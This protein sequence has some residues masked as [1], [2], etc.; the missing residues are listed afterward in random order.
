MTQLQHPDPLDL[1]E[2]VAAGRLRADEAERQLH[3]GRGSRSGDDTPDADVRELRQLIGAARAVR[4]HA[5]ATLDAAAVVP[6][7]TWATGVPAGTFDPGPLRRG[8]VRPRSSGGGGGRSSRRPWLLVA[9]A[10]AVG[11]G[12]VGTS[13]VGG[14]RAGPNPQP[15]LHVAIA[16]PT[17]GPTSVTATSAPSPTANRLPAAAGRFDRVCDFGLA[18]GTV[19]WVSTTVALYR[20]ADAGATWSIVSPQ[21]WSA[22]TS[23]TS[24]FADSVTAYSFLAGSPARIAATH[25]GGATWVLADVQAGVST[26]APAFSFQTATSGSVVFY[27]ALKSDPVSIYSTTDGG[28]TW[29]GPRSG[30]GAIGSPGCGHQGLTPLLALT[31]AKYDNKPFDNLLQLSSDGGATWVNRQLPVSTISPKNSLK[32]VE[33]LWGDGSG[34]VVMQISVQGDEQVYRSSD[35]GQTWQLLRDFG[36]PTHGALLPE[37]LSASEWVFV[38]DVA[39]VVYSTADGGATWRTTTGSISN[40]RSASFGS[41]DLGWAT[42]YCGGGATSHGPDNPVCATSAKGTILVTT[43]GGQTWA[44]IGQ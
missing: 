39:S 42:V 15:T 16:N 29:T 25:D 36:Q 23:T 24:F 8:A 37:F 3:P 14:N 44:P 7:E 18:S 43:N 11:A 31:N 13:I 12:L 26:A 33:G 27:G 6:S 5:R 19:G 20:T 17:A 38:A 41:P 32:W 9:A 10:V 34:F 30:V 21:G 35:D 28:T 40:L 22:A 4:A 1:A 2:A